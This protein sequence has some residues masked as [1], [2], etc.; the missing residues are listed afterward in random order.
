MRRIDVTCEP[1]DTGW[2]CLG[3]VSEPDGSSEHRVAV[4]RPDLER[5]APGDAAPDDLVRRS[6][7][8]LLER[9][10]KESILSRFD[11]SDIRSYFPEFDRWVRD[12]DLER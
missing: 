11:V 3:T 7:E 12:L 2:L 4:G 1:T 6:F 8:F 10:P 9:E 5:L